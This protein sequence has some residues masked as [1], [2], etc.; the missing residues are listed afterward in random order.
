[1]GACQIVKKDRSKKLELIEIDKK[2]RIGEKK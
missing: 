2:D 1:M